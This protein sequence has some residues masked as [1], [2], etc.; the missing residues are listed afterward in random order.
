M[1][2]PPLD[3]DSLV[4]VAVDI[5]RQQGLSAL[6]MRA[7]G[8]RFQV[9]PMAIYRHVDDRDHL[10]RLVVNRI[11]AFVQPDVAPDADWLDRARAWAVAQRG[12]L[13]QYPG[14]AAW[15]VSHG[16]PGPEAYR[17]LELLASTLVD[18]GFDDDEVARGTALIMSWTFSRTAIEDDA[19]SRRSD[20]RP[21]RADAFV[22]GL[23][24][25]DTA[26]Y[27]TAA[28]VGPMFF[29]LPMQEIFDTGLDWI[30]AGLD[31]RRLVEG[32]T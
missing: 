1:E 21:S 29:T 22:A 26:L 30:L 17:L 16:P 11:G 2:G 18:G 9:T 10:V 7:L 3:R 5:A 25:V 12:V 19:D 15:L 14:V 28:R 4:R 8:G 27:P 13:R 31:G 6:T 20:R 32:V 23:D 24:D